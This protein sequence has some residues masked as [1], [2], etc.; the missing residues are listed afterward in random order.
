VLVFLLQ[1]PTLLY[2]EKCSVR[3]VFNLIV[4]ICTAVRR[5]NDLGESREV[6]GK[7]ELTPS[8]G[9]RE[10]VCK[11]M[12][13]LMCRITAIATVL[14]VDRNIRDVTVLA[15]LLNDIGAFFL[16]STMPPNSVCCSR[17]PGKVGANLLKLGRI[18]SGHFMPKWEHID[19]DCGAPQGLTTFASLSF[20]ATGQTQASDARLWLGGMV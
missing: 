16:V 12:Q 2:P 7:H 6:S 1:K 11:S 5:M 13:Q 8:A 9:G 10:P 4:R 17:A 18:C 3:C 19:L 14:T 20:K 15:A